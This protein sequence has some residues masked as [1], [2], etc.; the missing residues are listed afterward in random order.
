MQKHPDPMAE[1]ESAALAG[2]EA[3]NTDA[4][5]EERKKTIVA[6]IRT[7]ESKINTLPIS[8]NLATFIGL[9]LDGEAQSVDHIVAE[10]AETIL[11][12]QVVHLTNEAIQLAASGP[13][14][15]ALLIDAAAMQ[16]AQ[17]STNLDEL[18]ERLSNSYT[19]SIQAKAA[20]QQLGTTANR[21]Q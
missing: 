9:C 3:W 4:M 15:S 19:L 12:A 8:A 20:V 21:K 17:C 11:P 5:T 18:V 1:M 6:S 7:I 14:A 2:L 16:A 13:D 10:Y